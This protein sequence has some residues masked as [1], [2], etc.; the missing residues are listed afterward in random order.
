VPHEGLEK[1]GEY[2]V[3]TSRDLEDNDTRT[4]TVWEIVALPGKTED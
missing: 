1:R 3:P 4:V 2:V